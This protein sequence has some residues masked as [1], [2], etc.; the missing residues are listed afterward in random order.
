M[1]AR[2]ALANGLRDWDGQNGVTV[3]LQE[4]NQGKVRRSN[5]VSAA[6]HS[7]VIAIQDADL[8]YDLRIYGCCLPPLLR[9]EADVVYGT[10][11]GGAPER[12][13]VLFTNGAIN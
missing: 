5:E 4:C 11:F 2:T 7:D 6:S 13:V 10:R 9:N 1:V 3:L 8:E 12:L